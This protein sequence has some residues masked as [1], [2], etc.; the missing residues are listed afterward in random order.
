M[1]KETRT[2]LVVAL[3][4]PARERHVQKRQCINSTGRDIGWWLLLGPD[5]H[6]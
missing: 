3:A 1:R 5:R 6:Q 4:P 2:Q